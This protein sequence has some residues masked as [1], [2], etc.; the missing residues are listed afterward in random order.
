[1]TA[2]LHGYL[3]QEASALLSRLQTLLPLAHTMPMV[4]AA[5]PC[6]PALQNIEQHL[7]AQRAAQYQR[8]R[9]FRHWLRSAAGQAAP[10]HALQ[11]RFTILKLR[12]NAVLDQLDIFADV[13]TQRGEY[14]YGT[15]MAALDFAAR[16]AL[17]KPGGYYHPL[18]M[19]CYLE[20]GHGAAIR[21]ARTRLPGGASN[22]VSI[23]RVPRERMVGS[24]IAASLFHEVGHQG[25]AQLDLVNEL[26]A[27]LQ[28]QSGKVWE[29]WQRWR[30]E[31]L[32]DFWAL[33]Q[34][35]VTATTGLMLVVLLPQAFVFRI[36][37]DAPHPFPW[38]RVQ[39]SCHLGERLFPDPQWQRIRH[40]WETLYP[41][42]NLATAERQLVASLLA[43]LPQFADLLLAFRPSR[44]HGKRLVDLFP[45]CERQPARLRRRFRLWQRQPSLLY[46][47]PPGEVFA[48]L[49]Q[50]REDGVLGAANE[51]ELL[52]RLFA[53]WA[54]QNTGIG[55]ADAINER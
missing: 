31:I 4:A 9:A 43:S 24:G 11:R 1:M 15:W 50:A 7:Q 41:L 38:L 47:R 34:L 54:L 12:L 5:A 21:R 49:G 29:Y 53:H 42:H 44:L 17:H 10:A 55:A 3:D 51:A 20:R 26:G 40:R 32:A 6:P 37:L 18:P 8:I 33:A 13:L 19:L 2:A 25:A 48:A 36:G 52:K 39:I 27:V 30:S 23:I 16:D 28:Q 35:G 45:L 14:Q 22:P 46:S